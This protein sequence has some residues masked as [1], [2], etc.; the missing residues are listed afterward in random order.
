MTIV[1]QLRK[2]TNAIMINK[3]FS[4]F[5]LFLTTILFAGCRT[6]SFVPQTQNVPLFT[7]KHQLQADA[8][9]A[10]CAMD[11][12]VAYSPINHLGVLLNA[13]KAFNY[14]KPEIAAGTFYAINNKY[15]G[16]IYGGFST[17]DLKANYSHQTMDIDEQYSVTHYIT[18]INENNYFFQP[19]I[20]IHISENESFAI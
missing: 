16:E 18:H 8:T 10:P 11:L 15:V 6:Y 14:F 4:V 20:G 19:N 9:L 13:Q 2:I 17:S 12:Q 1:N 5:I 7:E 3:A